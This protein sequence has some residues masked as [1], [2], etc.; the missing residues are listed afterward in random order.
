MIV[1]ERHF[2]LLS[3]PVEFVHV[4]APEDYDV[5]EFV[6]VRTE[7][8]GITLKASTPPQSLV[9]HMLTTKNTNRL[10]ENDLQRLV[11]HLGLPMG[12]RVENASVAALI[13]ALATHFG[14]DADDCCIKF[15]QTEDTSGTCY[16]DDA[17]A[18]AVY[19]ELDPDD[20]KEFAEIGAA[21]KKKKIATCRRSLK[22]N[23]AGTFAERNNKMRRGD[24]SKA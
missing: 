5:M 9:K 15:Q 2:V 8:F 7:R 3:A 11:A 23:F 18:E 4:V 21:I 24:H 1:G 22:R 19:N 14:F 10:S 12:S 6:G 17:F 16:T 20:Q 13:G